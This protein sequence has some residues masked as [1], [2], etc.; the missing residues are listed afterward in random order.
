MKLADTTQNVS[1]E[2][3]SKSKQFQIKASANAFKILSSTM[4]SDPIR[5]IIRELSCNAYDSHVAAGYPEKAFTVKL[6]NSIDKSFYVEDYG[7][8]LSEDDVLNV[9]STYFE[10]TKTESNDFVGALGLGSKTPFS[11][12]DSFIVVS[13]FNGKEMV[14]T[15][16]IDTHGGPSIALVSSASTSEANGVRVEIA[17]K[18]QDIHRFHQKAAVVFRPFEFQPNIVGADI[19]IA[20]YGEHGYRAEHTVVKKESQTKSFDFTWDLHIT[21]QR[22]YYGQSRIIISQGNIEYP[23]DQQQLNFEIPRW[24]NGT[25]IVVTVPIGA[26]DFAA[27]REE[28]HYIG[29][30]IN[31]IHDAV[32]EID[33]VILEDLMGRVNAIKTKYEWTQNKSLMNECSRHEKIEWNG[34]PVDENTI[35][36]FAQKDL[37]YSLR[38]AYDNNDSGLSCQQGYYDEYNA[39]DLDSIVIVDNPHR[40][41]V[42]AKT[43]DDNFGVLRIE[44]E[45]QEERARI[46]KEIT[47]EFG[48]PDDK[49]HLTSEIILP[50]AEPRDK[51]AFMYHGISTYAGELYAE[52]MRELNDFGDDVLVICAPYYKKRP[53]DLEEAEHIKTVLSL[54]PHAKFDNVDYESI[55]IIGVPLQYFKKIEDDTEWITP[56]D[57]ITLLT[58]DIVNSTDYKDVLKL[59]PYIEI[60]TNC[61][62]LNRI[63]GDKNTYGK[64]HNYDKVA[65]M[66]RRINELRQKANYHLLERT[67][68]AI[69][70]NTSLVND[71]LVPE[72][73]Q[74]MYPMLKMVSYGYGREEDFVEYIDLVNR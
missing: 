56:K 30:A 23:V 47:A 33:S 12:T 21:S 53:N 15:A 28:L 49:V 29:T 26:F 71:D 40:A 59:L 1:T 24:M 10:S 34:I 42:K 54:I 3:L 25:T 60:Y 37:I 55:R 67:A 70:N 16:F 65:K 19:S 63:M 9:Y 35:G 13:R 64:M 39:S 2:G 31:D 7:I 17:I 61:G 45:T 58:D 6:P 51:A 20:N 50:K 18:D 74:N 68:N 44:A 66:Y 62:F 57:A 43:L 69:G 22:Y 41:I 5:A 52:D 72:N 32:N 48:F 4:Y 38:S 27:S 8:G 11:Y 73:I 36:Y 46:G 14:F